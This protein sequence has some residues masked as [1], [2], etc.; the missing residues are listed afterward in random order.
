MRRI[1]LLALPVTLAMAVVATAQIRFNRGPRTAGRQPP[2]A[3]ASDPAATQSATTQSGPNLAD[4]ER[5]SDEQAIRQ[6]AELMARHYNEGNA[7]AVA[8]LFTADAELVDESGQRLHG[9]QAIE[10]SFAAVFKAVPSTAMTIKVESVRFLSPTVALEE[11]LSSI[12]HEPSDQGIPS[13]YSVVHV[14]HEGQW[15]M[16]LAHDLES[17]EAIASAELE[18]LGWLVGSWI[19]ETPEAVVR[20]TFRWSETRQYLFS[21]FSVQVHGKPVMTGTQ[22]IGWDPLARQLRSWV[23]DSEGGY[24]EGLW[25]GKGGDWLVKSSGA[26]RDGRINSATNVYHRL[27]ADRYSFKSRDRV[28]GGKLSED[29]E[30]IAVREPPRPAK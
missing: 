18:Q 19:D 8:A 12:K 13:R 26:T 9:R 21:H 15:Q 6:I 24:T 16:V 25:T 30:T 11:G 10:Q 28:L 23:F 22:R 7:K 4:A 2:A 5:T 1:L 20:T 27:S 29:I 17:S 3:P 14:K